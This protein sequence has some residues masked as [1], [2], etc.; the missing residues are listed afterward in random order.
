MEDDCFP[1]FFFVTCIFCTQLYRKRG[2]E[3]LLYVLF[4][5]LW[6]YTYVIVKMAYYILP[7]VYMYKCACTLLNIFTEVQVHSYTPK[8]CTRMIVIAHSS[9]SDPIYVFHGAGSRF[10]SQYGSG[11]LFNTDPDPDS[12]KKNTFFQ[13][14]IQKFCFSTKKVGILFH[15]E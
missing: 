3:I 13:R 6:Y 15:K 5:I 14:Q 4:H 11:L 7:T 10:F 12:G 9:V 2:R 1:Q 8:G